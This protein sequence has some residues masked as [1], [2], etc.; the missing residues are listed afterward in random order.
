MSPT[1]FSPKG[2]GGRP[3]GVPKGGKG[4]GK[5]QKGKDKGNRI[6]P[7][8]HTPGSQFTGECFYCGKTGHRI[9]DCKAKQTMGNSQAFITKTTSYTGQD[10]RNLEL[11]LNAEGLSRCEIC[12]A[13]ECKGEGHCNPDSIP[14]AMA[15]TKARYVEDGLQHLARA[16]KAT[17]SSGIQSQ[18]IHDHTTYADVL[19]MSQQ[20][21]GGSPP[22]VDLQGYYQSP[23]QYFRPLSPAY[24][25]GQFDLWENADY[26]QQE[27]GYYA[28]DWA[29][30]NYENYDYSV[31]Q[32]VLLG[33]SYVYSPPPQMPYWYGYQWD[34][35]EPQYQYGSDPYF[36]QQMALD[37]AAQGSSSEL[38]EE[39]AALV[40]AADLEQTLED[41]D[42]EPGERDS[43]APLW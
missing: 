10:A 31:D 38:T 2:K 35:A 36:Q 28:D 24:G 12:Y 23:D 16:A 1:P 30:D 6:A 18:V 33:Q 37:T 3:K 32:S 13:P 17:A 39:E 43:N 11:L 4:K 42:Y 14:S 5:P 25:Y 22:T 29:Y 8:A 40:L 27:N 41:D 20:A 21:Y 34:D 7:V 26:Y 15:Y 19:A 9:A